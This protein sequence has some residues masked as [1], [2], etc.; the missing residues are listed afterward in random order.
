MRVLLVIYDNGGY[1]H[2]FPLGSAYIAS[3]L[4]KAGHKVE[5]YNQVN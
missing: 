1:M 2:S 5:I 3:A 4:Q